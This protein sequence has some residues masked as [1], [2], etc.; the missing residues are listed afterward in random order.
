M[1]MRPNSRRNIPRFDILTSLVRD[2]EGNGISLGDFA[3]NVRNQPD[4]TRLHRHDYPELFFFYRGT[5]SHLNDF[6]EYAV[7]AP[8]M[9]FVDA[10]HVHAWPDASRLRGD[11]LSFDAG[12]ALCGQS[13]EKTPALFLP[14]AP[15]VIPL[16]KPAAATAEQLFARIRREWEQRGEGWLR[17]VRSCL[18][19]LHVD[20]V[21]EHACQAAG[22]AP[23]DNAATRLCRE[24]LL[25]LEKNLRADTGPRTLAAGLGVSADHL[26]ATM[27]DV[28]GKPAMQHIQERLMLEARRLLAHSRL[29]AAEIA[30]HLGYEDV[31]YFG[32]VF[33]KREGMTPGEFRKHH[34][35]GEGVVSPD[36]NLASRGRK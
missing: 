18:Q 23:P 8:C 14:P 35:C 1:R 16:P 2:E 36:T 22:P 20:A 25:L 31:S 13:L 33:R 4:R 15:V 34:A 28:T 11:M 27:R 17:A 7:C 6:E 32:R 12:F 3:T 24:F 21:R 10:G 30:Y 26:S 9:V 19:L 5:G 29:D